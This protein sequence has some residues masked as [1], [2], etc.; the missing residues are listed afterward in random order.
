MVQLAASCQELVP[1]PPSNVVVQAGAA[2]DEAVTTSD[3][4]A[5]ANAIKRAR[6]ALV[7]VMIEVMTREVAPDPC[8]RGRP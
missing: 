4:S 8:P 6:R 2:V 7:E 5:A 1:A 3:S